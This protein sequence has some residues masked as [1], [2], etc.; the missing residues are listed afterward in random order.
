[1]NSA[2][3][4]TDS[5]DVRRTPLW[6]ASAEI[7]A[8]VALFFVYAGDAPPAVNEAHYLVK[9]KNFW[10][11]GYCSED[12]FAASGKA[13]AT[14]YWTFGALTRW[15]SLSVTAWIGRLVGWTLIAAGFGDGALLVWDAGAPSPH[16]HPL[17]PETVG[18]CIGLG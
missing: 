14:F 13:H 10:D 4:R 18:A 7:A 9:A 15:V 8:L 16:P 17:P 1:M 12:L 5:D 2:T 3:A 11:P 6:K